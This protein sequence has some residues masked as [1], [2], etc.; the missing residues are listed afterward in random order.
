MARRAGVLSPVV[1]LRRRAVYKGLF[2][3]SRGWMVVGAV[4]WGPRLMKKVLG[5][6]EQIV[7]TE[8][9]KPGQRVCIEAITP[10]TRGER[11]A[12]RRAR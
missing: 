9:L 6:T 11:R 7:A 5:R 8:V 1:A 4:V 3:G 12:I 10:V 2:G